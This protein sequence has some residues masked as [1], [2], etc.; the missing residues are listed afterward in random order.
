MSDIKTTK[1]P[2]PYVEIDRAED[3]LKTA[4]K[5]LDEAQDAVQR[6]LARVRHIRATYGAYHPDAKDQPVFPVTSPTMNRVFTDHLDL[7][8]H[9]WNLPLALITDANGDRWRPKIVL[10]YEPA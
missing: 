6:A 1:A 5:H 7:Q 10:V 3:V 2:V 8:E 4:E 9:F